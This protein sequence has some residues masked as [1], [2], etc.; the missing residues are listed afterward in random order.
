[1]GRGKKQEGTQGEEL[2]R[3][4]DEEDLRRCEGQETQ[5]YWS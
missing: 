4:K 2:G 5:S 3:D 1:L